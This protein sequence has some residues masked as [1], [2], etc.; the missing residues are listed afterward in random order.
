[1]KIYLGLWALFF[2][3]IRITPLESK[4]PSPKEIIPLPLLSS[5]I[6]FWRSLKTVIRRHLL[7]GI[8]YP[9]MFMLGIEWK[10]CISHFFQG[11]SQVVLVVENPT[12]NAWDVRERFD[13][14]LRGIPMAEGTATHS[15]ILVWRILWAKEPGLFWA[16]VHRVTK[17]QTQLK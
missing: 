11:A 9:W 1:M 14:S 4:K 16:T 17:S 12:A 6:E 3:C 7:G 5:S 2:K 10:C 13:P 8:K 15:S